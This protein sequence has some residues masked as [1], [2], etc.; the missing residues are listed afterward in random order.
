V[1]GR[2]SRFVASEE[3]EAKRRSKPIVPYKNRDFPNLHLWPTYRFPRSRRPQKGLPLLPV[4]LSLEVPAAASR[5]SRKSDQN[6]FLSMR[7][8]SSALRF[9]GEQRHGSTH[10]AFST[11]SCRLSATTTLGRTAKLFGLQPET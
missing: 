11:D 8:F 10:T 3:R 6:F 1:N 2:V 7:L 4:I 5:S 9:W